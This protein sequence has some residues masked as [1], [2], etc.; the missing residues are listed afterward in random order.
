[1]SSKPNSKKPFTDKYLNLGLDKDVSKHSQSK[2]NKNPLLFNP[3]INNINTNQ[4]KNVQVQE[5]KCTKENKT[6]LLFNSTNTNPFL[7]GCNSNEKSNGVIRIQVFKSHIK[8]HRTM[9]PIQIDESA[10]L[11]LLQQQTV[12]KEDKVNKSPLILNQVNDEKIQYKMLI[13]KIAMQLKKK[14]RPR[15]KGFFYM[16]VIRSEKYMNL[17]KKIAQSIKN[18]LGIHPPTHGAFGSYIQKEEEIKLIKKKKETYK[19]LIKK[20]AS[21]LKKR[22][23][24]PTCKIIKIYESYRALI[25]K[26]AD[27]LKKSMNQNPS[28]S[29]SDNMQNNNNIITQ[30]NIEVEEINN[31]NNEKVMDIDTTDYDNNANANNEITKEKEII[32][33]IIVEEENNEDNKMDI[34]MNNHNSI[35]NST[36]FQKKEIQTELKKEDSKEKNDI[37][38][39][40]YEQKLNYESTSKKKQEENPICNYTFSKMEVIDNN[41]L[42]NSSEKKP[43]LD[44]NQQNNEIPDVKINTAEII[45]SNIKEDIQ[46]FQ[47]K[48]KDENYVSKSAKNKG[49][50]FKFSLMKKE[51]L[52]EFNTERKKENKSHSKINIK[53]NI[54]NLHEIFNKMTNIENKENISN[55]LSLQDIESTKAN[56]ISQFELFLSQEN[57]EIINNFPVSTNEKNIY[58]FQQSNFWYLVITFLFYKNNNLSLYNILYLLDQYN[59]WAKDKNIE[60]F[61]SMKARIKDYITSHNSKEFIDQFLFMN[62]LD[63]LDKIFEKFESPNIYPELDTKNKKSNEYKE[64]KVNDIHFLYDK[65]DEQCKC[66]LCTN[67]DACIQKV[68]DLNKSRVEIVNNSSIDFLKKEITP[69]DIIKKN[70]SCIVFHNNEELFYQGKSEKKSNTIFSKSKTILEDGGCF[71]FIRQPVYHPSTSVKEERIENFQVNAISKENEDKK[72]NNEDTP[73][74]LFDKTP[75]QEK[76]EDI[77]VDEDILDDNSPKK[78]FKNISKSEKKP[79]EE[80]NDMDDL[81]VKSEGKEPNDTA[82]DKNEEENNSEDESKNIKKEKKSRKGKSRKKNNTKIN[83]KK[84]DSIT[85]EKKEAEKEENAK[86][87]P[88]EEEKEEK[89]VK[90]KRKSTNRSSLKKNKSKNCV[91]DEE[92]EEKKEKEEKEEKEEKPEYVDMTLGSK[93]EKKLENE[94]IINNSK[95][96]KSKTP[97]KKKSRKH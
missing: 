50:F 7:D 15:T 81:L 40:T 80:Q 13:K 69:E 71:E 45:S 21:Q 51:D 42:P 30:Q 38:A 29:T 16:K 96:K 73:A 24:L 59:A 26:I 27:A 82:I 61:Y 22:V 28:T 75:E 91:K 34:E 46:I 37:K 2:P 43:P 74:E 53:L 94:P 35:D 4:I 57:I 52:N 90:K 6:Q 68:C 78:N 76:Q 97:N 79:I 33:N 67:D 54:E 58:L 1:M 56:F 93:S 65:K 64:I 55:N 8:P 3:F 25:K 70:N 48:N 88:K 10:K 95:R 18:K 86:D 85:K 41:E 92:K 47:D 39:L 87:E 63:N 23:K 36:P 89:S 77:N 5:K 11:K 83:K 60:I 44:S 32:N 17:V 62:K 9:E 66:E 20:I 12:V 19:L 31:V 72:I 49:E 14:I 84:K